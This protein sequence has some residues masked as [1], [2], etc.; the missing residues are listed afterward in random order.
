MTE[1]LYYRDAFL[2][3]F[4]A[5]VEDIREVSRQGGRQVWQ[6]SLDRSA[7]YP[8]SGGQPHDLGTLTARSPSGAVLA[9]A[10]S[11][12]A[13]DDDG[14]VWHSTEKPLLAGTEIEGEIDWARR[15]DHMQQHS[16]Q[17]L[18]SACFLRELGAATV[19]FHLGAEVSSIDLA[20]ADGVDALDGAEVERVSA[21]ANLLVAEDRAMRVH[22]VSPERSAGDACGRKTAEVA[23]ARG[24]SS[25]DRDGGRGVERLRRHACEKRR[26]RLVASRSGAWSGFGGAWC[27]WS[28]VAGCEPHA[29]RGKIIRWCGRWRLRFLRRRKDCRR[30][31]G[32]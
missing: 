28:F 8:D 17:H 25:R 5:R 21:A 32:G 14:T 4:T 24:G 27:G 20:L 22:F 16:G 10:V 2:T 18:L 31:C 23:G 6:V 12:V 26:D 3:R 13:E 30:R 1:R 9:A 29:R 19:S 15:L 11:A 7:F